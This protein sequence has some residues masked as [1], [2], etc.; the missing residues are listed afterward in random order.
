V[1]RLIRVTG[2]LQREGIVTHVIADHLEDM[3]HRL[4]ALAGPD[5]KSADHRKGI[6]S[7]GAAYENTLARAD[8]VKN[9]GPET[10]RN[11]P[12]KLFPSRDF[13]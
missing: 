10:S 6:G 7:A 3:T 1:A 5:F 9:P 2:R 8:E 12:R 13:H 4:R 11:T